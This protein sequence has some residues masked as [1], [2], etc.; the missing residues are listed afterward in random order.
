VE[1]AEMEMFNSVNFSKAQFLTNSQ[2]I[3]LDIERIDGQISMFCPLPY[4]VMVPA[5]MAV[6]LSKPGKI[7]ADGKEVSASFNC[8][9]LPMAPVPL[10]VFS[11]RSFAAEYDKT[12][13]VRLEGF[14][15]LDGQEF[16]TAVF[17]VKTEARRKDLKEE[18]DG[19]KDQAASLIASEGMVLLRNED[20]TLPLKSETKLAIF[21]GAQ[22]EYRFA[23]TGAGSVNPRYVDDVFDGLR[24]HSSFS[25]V[26]ELSAFYADRSFKMPDEA[27][28]KKAQTEAG[29]A[30][31][32]LTRRTGE[33]IDNLPVKG[34]YYLTDEEDGLI[35]K[36]ASSFKKTVVVINSGYPIDVRWAE[37]YKVGAVIYNSFAGMKG[38]F[39][40]MEILDGRVN[41]SGKTA[42]S[43]PRDY[44]SSSA[45]SSFL[46]G[47]ELKRIE[48]AADKHKMGAKYYYEEGIY[49]GYRYY[50]TFQVPVSYPFGFGLSYTSF[51][52]KAEKLSFDGETAAVQ[53]EV[54]NTG[55]LSGKEVVQIYLQ[56]P[57]GKIKKAAHVLV[58]F[59]KT[60]LLKPGA[61][62]SLQISWPNQSFCFF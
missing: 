27:L 3:P 24:L 23:E 42:D 6:D 33:N 47:D 20:C 40:L 35:K 4:A 19:W 31:V 57:Q 21:G 29:A 17:F 12:Y 15:S 37:K 56:A 48:Y 54:R 50:D 45:A 46:A 30:L 1:G 55:K 53:A 32:F 59:Q 25:Y 34:E 10:L 11:A 2:P 7:F 14:K 18:K 62:E 61:K 44:P 13:Q 8:L 51:D 60:S 22:Y 26:E 38:S 39:A 5:T 28:L 9:K 36:V 52:L 43:W 41:P 58:G 16:P 49:V